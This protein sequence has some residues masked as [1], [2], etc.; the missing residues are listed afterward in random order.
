M[1]MIFEMMLKEIRENFHTV[2]FYLV[3]LLAVSLF[4]AGSLL[5]VGTSNQRISDYRKDFAENE[6]SLRIASQRLLDLARYNQ[7]L[8]KKTN[9]F[10]FISE[11]NEKYLPNKFETTIF[12]AGFPELKGRG[13]VLLKDYKNMDWEFIVAVV[14]S[15]LAFVMSYDAVCGEKEQKTL[16]LMFSNSVNTSQV[17]LGKFL[18]L[19]ISLGIPLLTGIVL[20][21]AVISLG[22]GLSLSIGRILLFICASVLYLSLFLLIGMM[23]SSLVIQSVSSAIILLFIWVIAAFIIPASGNLIACKIYPLPTRARI[24][25]QIGQAQEDVYKTRYAKTEA[26]RWDGHLDRPWVPLRSQWMADSIEVR[27]KIYDD[28]LQRMIRQVEK[29]KDVTK[30]SP[31]SVFRSLTE[32]IAGTGVRRFRSFYAQITR[33]KNQLYQFVE[34]RDRADPQ[35][36]HLLPLAYQMNVGISV[37][38]VDFSLVPKF[39]E[40]IPSLKDSF[41]PIIID[42]AILVLLSLVIFYVGYLL[43]VRYDKR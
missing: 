9:P 14:L 2:R 10:E 21:V 13:N 28:Y 20:G 4:A 15:F 27:N 3:L 19:L 41:H 12:T 38:P 22:G 18:G 8:Y 5:F 34:S 17:F 33:Y 16:A 11:A 43:F 24:V 30:I 31:V 39:E 29:T 26:G 7:S 35:S 25:E 23:V 42:F 1:I 6:N 32:E 36:A 37:K 40:K